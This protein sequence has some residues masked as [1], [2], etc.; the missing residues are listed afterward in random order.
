MSLKIARELVSVAKRLIASTDI[1][2]LIGD[3]G[4][5]MTVQITTP[6]EGKVMFVGKFN[7][8]QTEFWPRRN[9][10]IAML[11]QNYYIRIKWTGKRNI[12]EILPGQKYILEIDVATAGGHSGFL[13]EVPFVVGTNPDRD[14]ERLLRVVI[15]TQI[16]Q[17]LKKDAKHLM[18]VADSIN[19]TLIEDYTSG[20]YMGD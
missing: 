17:R 8:N 11:V 1:I 20:R 2:Q 18:E 3:I 14:M 12:E 6:D 15:P 19:K 7:G 4:K 13:F 10:S 16:N 5:N 9:S